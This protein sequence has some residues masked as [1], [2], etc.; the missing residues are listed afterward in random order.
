M[1]DSPAKQKPPQ[2]LVVDDQIINVEILTD[3]LK[4]E[5]YSVSVARDGAT[6]LRVLERKPRDFDAVL[7]DRMMP[8]MDGIE[9]L[10]RIKA[11]P[12]MHLVPV[13]MQTAKSAQAE[14]LE[15]LRAGAHYYLTKP[16]R[17]EM[18]LAVVN[19]AVGDY[20]DYKSM[21][22]RAERALREARDSIASIRLLE[23]G[24]FRF[25]HLSDAQSLAALLANLF[26]DSQRAAVGLS[27][28]L[29][30][31]VEHGN[32]QITY[33]EKGQLLTNRRLLWMEEVERRL[34]LPEYADKY[35]EVTLQHSAERLSVTIRDAGD[36]FNWA[37]YLEFD[38]KRAFDPHG[39]GIAMARAMSFDTLQYNDVG[40]EVT[41]TVNLASEENV[42]SSS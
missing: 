17:R 32:L 11:H 25:R 29:I 9:V 1:T 39:R 26:P 23:Q 30:N 34:A 8:K 24:R 18:L 27:E 33:A 28:L 15:G 21:Q 38:P 14:I 6:A 4:Q 7:L 5:G 41:V 36:G 31:A 16:L 10:K 42:A 3:Y 37:D 22:E 20:R 2:V 35:V 40:N 12:E 19:T 13:I